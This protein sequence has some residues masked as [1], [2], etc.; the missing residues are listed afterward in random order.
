MNLITLKKQNI[1]YAI[2]GSYIYNESKAKDIDVLIIE[3]N[4]KPVNNIYDFQ[5]ISKDVF[6]AHLKKC[7]IRALEC[8]F[9]PQSNFIE[10]YEKFID[11][12]YLRS[13]ISQKSSHSYVKAKKKMS[14]ENEIYIGQKSLYHSLRILLF[15]IQLAKYKKIINFSEANHYL[16]KIMLIENWNDLELIYKKEYNRLHSEFKLACPK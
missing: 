6:I 7:D 12:S 9:S 3:S 13:A 11:W 16:E 1:E 8:I 5:Y 15:G 2:F 14:K 4:I 10:D